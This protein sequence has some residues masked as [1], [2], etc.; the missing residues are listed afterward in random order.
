VGQDDVLDHL[1]EAHEIVAELDEVRTQ[2]LYQTLRGA[3]YWIQDMVA[4]L[5]AHD[6]WARTQTSLH[7]R[8]QPSTTDD[9]LTEIDREVDNFS[10]IPFVEGAGFDLKQELTAL[11]ELLAETTPK[12]ET[13]CNKIRATIDSDY[14]AGVVFL[15]ASRRQPAV[16]AV[17]DELDMEVPQLEREGVHIVGPDEIRIITDLDITIFPNSLPRSM[18]GLYLLNNTTGSQIFTYESGREGHIRRDCEWYLEAIDSRLTGSIENLCPQPVIEAIGS[19][20][21][22]P[23]VVETD[24]DSQSERSKLLAAVESNLS[25]RGRSGAGN[26]ISRIVVTT[27]TG[28]K[29]TYNSTDRVLVSNSEVDGEAYEWLRIAELSPGNTFLFIDPELRSRLLSSLLEKSYEEE[30]G[31]EFDLYE[32]LADWWENIQEIE[33]QADSIAE[34]HSRLQRAGLDRNYSTVRNWIRSAQEAD[35]PLDL[36]EDSD[37]VIGPEET[38]DIRIIGEVFGITEFRDQAPVI[39]SVMAACRGFNRTK[40][41]EVSGLIKSAVSDDTATVWDFIEEKQVSQIEPQSE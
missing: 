19:D 16:R 27:D 1:S 13:L 15:K 20:T 21:E 33:A 23:Q 38:E 32:I 5:E 39:G 11:F 17:C 22:H 12:F 26:E 4:P 6:H 35:G 28:E 40:G 2:A 10:S 3:V 7:G 37:L 9:M 41:K 30:I 31:G 24:E 34:V 18:A 8:Y 14:T 36:V 25:G 29:I